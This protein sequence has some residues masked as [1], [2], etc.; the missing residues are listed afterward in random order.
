MPLLNAHR[1]LQTV[2]LSCLVA[3]TTVTFSESAL[4]AAVL[5]LVT[6]DEPI[7]GGPCEGCEAVFQGLPEDLSSEARIA[8]LGE[9]GAPLQLSGTVRDGNGNPAPGTVVYAYQ[10]NAEGIYPRAE[11]FRGQAAQRHGLLRG[12]AQAGHGGRYRFETVR[13]ASYPNS[14]LPQHIHLHVIEPGRCTYYIDDIVFT[15]DPSLAPRQI[16]R[17]RGRGGRGVVTPERDGAGAW[18]V[19]RDIILGAAIPGYSSCGASSRR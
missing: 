13:P 12:W 1:P 8:P 15:D 6:G 14:G 2:A 16:E 19:E 10:T 17:S 9:P 5:S 7:V 11:R 3:W 18:L 4:P